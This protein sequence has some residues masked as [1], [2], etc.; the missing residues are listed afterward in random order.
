[1]GDRYSIGRIVKTVN[2]INPIGVNDIVYSPAWS[3]NEPIR[4]ALIGKIDINRDGRDDR[5]DLKR[6]IKAAGGIVD[7]DLPP[8][9]AGKET[10]KL[11]GEDA[12]Y[13]FDNR[14]PAVSGVNPREDT[15]PENTEFL[16][17][18]TEA[19]R[20]ARQNGVRPL[21][22]QRLLS[23]LS[24]DFSEPIRGRAEAKDTATM[25]NL[26]QGHRGTLPNPAEMPK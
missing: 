14:P 13:V 11:T 3:P 17:K 9:E 18:K 21:P 4:F 24:Y 22:I 8:P 12:W 5:D 2:M 10:G 1:M 25:R 26:L 19:E 16:K 7:Y 6:M 20:E 15:S 23:Y